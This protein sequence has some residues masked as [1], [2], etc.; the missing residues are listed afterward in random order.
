MEE[1]RNI[2]IDLTTA[3]EWYKGDNETLKKLAL[4]AFTEEELTKVELPKTFEEYLSTLSKHDEEE[5]R[6]K[7]ELLYLSIDRK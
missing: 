1:K 7:Y 2:Q 5:I 4:Q 3:K 6:N